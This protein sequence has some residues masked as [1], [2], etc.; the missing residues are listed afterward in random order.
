M[1]VRSLPSRE[2]DLPSCFP[3]QE[4]SLVAKSLHMFDLMKGCRFLCMTRLVP[5]HIFAVLVYKK[6]IKS[7]VSCQKVQ[8]LNR[9]AGRKLYFCICYR[10]Q[11]E[12]K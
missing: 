8:N 12:K 4:S 9:N 7:K 6:I 2:G 10:M 5:V 1:A 11:K 3:G